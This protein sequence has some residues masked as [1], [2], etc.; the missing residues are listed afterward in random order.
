[1]LA[2]RGQ[3]LAVQCAALGRSGWDAGHYGG[4][5]APGSTLL[6]RY[7]SDAA[8][9]EAALGGAVAPAPPAPAPAP[10]AAAAGIGL[11]VVVV[12][13]GVGAYLFSR[14]PPDVSRRVAGRSALF[15]RRASSGS[16]SA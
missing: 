3:A 8:Q 2:T 4:L 13:V 5:S 10:V 14:K 15:A 6:A 7:T 16:F 1:M 12:A 9:I 11:P